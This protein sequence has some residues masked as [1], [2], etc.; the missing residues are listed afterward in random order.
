M[1]CIHC[2]CKVEEII[3]SDECGATDCTD[4]NKG[5]EENLICHYQ[6]MR[7]TMVSIGSCIP[8]KHY[9]MKRSLNIAVQEL[10]IIE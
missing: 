6:H 2:H 1:Y 7:T 9:K 5:L 8:E 4:Y 10:E 3:K